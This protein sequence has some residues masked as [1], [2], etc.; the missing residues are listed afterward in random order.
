[1]ERGGSKVRPLGRELEGRDVVQ[2]Q[3]VLLPSLEEVE[4]GHDALTD[5]LGLGGCA[6]LGTVVD[7]A[8]VLHEH[9]QGRSVRPR[10]DEDVVADLLLVLHG[11]ELTV[12]KDLHAV[13]GVDDAEAHL[14]GVGGQG[15]AV[16][17]VAGVLTQQLHGLGVE[18]LPAL[19]EGVQGGEETG[20]AVAHEDARGQRGLVGGRAQ[21]DVGEALGHHGAEGVVA[22]GGV[23]ALIERRAVV[24]R[25]DLVQVVLLAGGAPVHEPEVG[26]SVEH[27]E[28][29]R[30][31]LEGAAHAV[32][33]L[34]AIAAGGRLPPAAEPAVPELHAHEG[35]G[36][37]VPLL[38]A[39]EGGEVLLG[40]RAEVARGKNGV[41]D[42]G[43]GRETR[44]PGT[45]GGEE[46]HGEAALRHEGRDR[47]EVPLVL[48]VRAVLVLHL[49]HEH[50]AAA[51]QLVGREARDELVVVGRDG[52]EEARVAAARAAVAVHEPRG[53][54]SPLPLGA[55]ERRRAND[56]V[57]PLAGRRVEEGLDVAQA[58]EAEGAL[59][60]LV[61]VPRHVGLDGVEAQGL[62]VMQRVRPICRVHTEVVDGAGAD[63]ERLAVEQEAA[64]PCGEGVDHDGPY[65]SHNWLLP[66]D[67]FRSRS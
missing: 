19:G 11:C 47:A 62:E 12:A 1:M 5:A 22:P 24:V 55:D 30:P 50:V 49:E 17:H 25:R 23:A 29:D 40:P 61:E 26:A 39:P 3:G 51:V 31:D 6:Q 36:A 41:V 21:G 66:D 42:E 46:G 56:G 63:L 20:H 64:P 57:E 9:V 16:E 32:G 8:H 58:V 27:V 59:M 28:V 43:A 54:A 18:G 14:V 52:P 4:V 33:Q 10:G 13:G 15:R 38:E 2:G 67:V 65:G 37:A 7:A 48:G 34:A 45:V 60:G 53:Q 35:L 44:L